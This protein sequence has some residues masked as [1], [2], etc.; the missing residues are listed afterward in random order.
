MESTIRT[1]DDVTALHSM[2]RY[3]KMFS[4][5]RSL[6]MDCT[7][8]LF[9]SCVRVLLSNGCFCGSTILAWS[10]Y[11][12]III[13]HYTVNL[14]FIK[15]YIFLK[16]INPKE[17]QPFIRRVHHLRCQYDCHFCITAVTREGMG[18]HGLLC[19]GIH[20]IFDKIRWNW[21]V[22]LSYTQKAVPISETSCPLEYR[23][24]H[25][26]LRSRNSDVSV[27]VFEPGSGH[28]G[29]VVDKVAP[30]Q[31]FSEYFGFLCQSSFHQLLHNHPHLSSGV[32]TIGQMWP[33][34]L[35]T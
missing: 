13:L 11:A 29:F 28:V 9:Y 6:E 8:P 18:C 32:C 27:I 30:G 12:T 15:W 1:V 34:Y 2:V 35:G 20:K 22:F 21:S 23:T 33:Q 3:T 26:V 14:N 5:S 16:P 19:H 10:K 7:T 31:V 24:M 17:I 4:P 25:K